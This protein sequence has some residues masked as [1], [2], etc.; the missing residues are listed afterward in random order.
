M[1]DHPRS[2]EQ[3]HRDY[4]ARF[5]A[6]VKALTD[7]VDEFYEQCDP[8]KENL[9]LYGE[10][11]GSWAVDLPAE[12]VPAELPEPCL[13]INFA[14]NGM[15]RRD[16]L[17]LVAV[18]SDAWLLSVAFYYG[19]RLD[20]EGRAKLFKTIND[21]P[22]LF[23][24]VMERAGRASAAPA[25]TGNGADAA[26]Q[27]AAGGSQQ[28]NRQAA[29]QPT[30]AAVWSDAPQAS[31]RLATM[32]DIPK[33]KGRRAELYWPDDK[34]WY[35]ITFH[36]VNPQENN[37]QAVYTSGEIEELDLQE[38]IQDGHLSILSQ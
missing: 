32:S 13:G 10:P 17:A 19:A 30:G 36:S 9:C 26:A 31:G 27:P 14:R 37:A 15:A 34:K 7:E 11:D 3:I 29:D 28:R 38:I 25:T 33:L 23:E 5:G 20:S 6:L 24:V 35:L 2:A 1:A 22:T 21:G 12:E 18:H 16:W 8:E 4:Q